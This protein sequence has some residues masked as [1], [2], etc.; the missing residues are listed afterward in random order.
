MNGAQAPP[1]AARHAPQQPPAVHI[2]VQSGYATDI[3]DSP[4]TSA[5]IEIL[6]EALEG[7]HLQMSRLELVAGEFQRL[8]NREKL[9]IERLEF[10]LE[11]AQS[12]EAYYRVLR[13]LQAGANSD[14]D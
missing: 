14:W 6:A 13:R 12:D 9:Q 2:P 5:T 8:M 1:P 7:A 10:A 3:P 11:K 4:N